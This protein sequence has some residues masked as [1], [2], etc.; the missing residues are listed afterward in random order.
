MT[1]YE[2]YVKKRKV[3]IF[4]YIFYFLQY[5]TVLKAEYAEGR[6]FRQAVSRRKAELQ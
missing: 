6:L 5:V 1:K 4:R 2:K 3:T